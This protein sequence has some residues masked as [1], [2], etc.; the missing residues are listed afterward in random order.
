MAELDATI[1]IVTRDRRDELREAVRSA[2]EQEG[3]IEVLV[4]DDG[5][6]DGT[7]EMLSE[8]FP[9]VRVARFD[10]NA[11][12]AARRNDAAALAGGDVIVSIDDDAVFPSHRVI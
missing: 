3:A 12:V 2:L 7:P 5:S 8:E 4:L 6:Q 10:D 1:A 11:G 9:D